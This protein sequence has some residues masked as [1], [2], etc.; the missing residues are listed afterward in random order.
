MS[1]PYSFHKALLKEV[2]L[3]KESA[4]MIGKLL[5]HLKKEDAFKKCVGQGADKWEDYLRDPEIGLSK[6]EATRLMQIYEVFVL[7][8]GYEEEEIAD[9]PTKSLFYLLPLAK[10]EDIK[11][12]VEQAKVLSQHDFRE[13]VY[14]KRVAEGVTTRTYEYMVMKKTKETGTMQKVHE[15]GSDI[16]KE[17]FNL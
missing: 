8:L 3:T 16:I 15:L 6:S 12:L 4:V 9:I 1:A 13:A 17:T 14:D 7:Q 5:Y 11:E 2:R 10:K